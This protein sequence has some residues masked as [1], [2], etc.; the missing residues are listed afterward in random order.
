[1]TRLASFVP[2]FVMADGGLENARWDRKCVVTVG[3]STMST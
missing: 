1:M 3:W 2:V